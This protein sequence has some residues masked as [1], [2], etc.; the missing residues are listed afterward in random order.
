MRHLFGSTDV[1]L[2][3]LSQQASC[4]I[5]TTFVLDAGKDV[6]NFALSGR[7]I[8]DA[9]RGQQR[10]IEFTR[11]IHSRLVARFLMAVEVALQLD[12]KIFPA[13]SRDEPLKQLASCCEAALFQSL[14]ERAMLVAGE[15]D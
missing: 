10:E 2:R 13:K 15:T 3:I 7:G 1:P 6:G 8:A 11:K 14:C 12:I 9:I 4:G 5:E